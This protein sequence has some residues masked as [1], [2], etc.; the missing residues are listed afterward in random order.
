VVEEQLGVDGLPAEHELPLYD[1]YAPRRS[2]RAAVPTGR[3]ASTTN[4]AAAGGEYGDEDDEQAAGRAAKKQAGRGRGRGAKKQPAGRGKGKAG[5]AGKAAKGGDESD[6]E[7]YDSQASSEGEEE[8]SEDEEDEFGGG[9]GGGGTMVTDGGTETGTEVGLVSAEAM[10]L[11]DYV[12][13]DRVLGMRL[14]GDGTTREYCIKVVDKSFRDLVWR[15]HEWLVA[16]APGKLRGFRCRTAREGLAD[17]GEAEGPEGGV[18]YPTT[19]VVAAEVVPAG[20]FFPVSYLLIDR[21]IAVRSSKPSPGAAA[22]VEY[23]CKWTGLGYSHATWEEAESL[24]SPADRVAVERYHYISKPRGPV[25]R[26][27]WRVPPARQLVQPPVFKPG[28]E[29]RDYQRVSFDWM[30]RNQRA[31][32]NVILGDEMGLGKTAQSVSILEHLRT[33]G[34][35]PGGPFLVVAPL[36][37]LTHWQRE[38]HKWTHMNAV[39]YD[40]SAADKAAC[41]KWDFYTDA[42][43]PSRP[44]ARLRDWPSGTHPFKFDCLLITYDTLR[45]EAPVLGTIMWQAM[46]LDEAHRLKDVNSATSLALRTQYVCGWMLML[47]GTPVQNNLSELFGLLHLLD[48][49]HFP[50]LPDF[51][52]RFCPGGVVEAARMPALAAALKPYLLRRMKEDVE[53]IPE[54]EECVVWVE[55][56]AD[57]RAY[58]KA[59]HESKMHV[60]LAANSRKNMPNSRNLLMELRH[61]CNHPFLLT[62]IQDDFTRRR[63]EAAA[64]AVPPV[65]PPGQVELLVSASGKMVLLAKLLP[66][67]KADGHK[68]LIFSQFKMVLNL[69]QDLCHAMGWPAERLDGDTT[70]AERQAGI[71][72]FNDPDGGGFVYLLSTRAGGMGITLTAADTA[73]IYDSDWNPQQDLQAMARCHRIGQTKSVRVYR[74]VTRGTYEEAILKAA[75]RKFGLDEALLGA[76]GDAD[77]AAGGPDPLADVARIESLLKHGVGAFSE[78]AVAETQRFV[79]EGIEDIL[80]KRVERRQVGS[81]KGNTFST[82]TFVAEEDGAAGGM[83]P[84]DALLGDGAAPSGLGVVGGPTSGAE[85]W[86]SFLP[87]AVARE[88][89]DPHSKR[90]FVLDGPRQRKRVDYSIKALAAAGR[91]DDYDL[92]DESDSDSGG[93]GGAVRTPSWTPTQVSNLET[94]LVSFGFG[95]REA[96]VSLFQRSATVIPK[97]EAEEVA[98]AL[99]E[100]LNIAV[101]HVTGGTSDAVATAKAAAAEE[102]K[103]K[104]AAAAANAEGAGPKPLEDEDV[105]AELHAKLEAVAKPACARKALSS[106]R[107]TLRMQ[108]NGARYALRLAER[109]ALLERVCPDGSTELVEFDVPACG[110]AQPPTPWWGLQEDRDLMRGSL[111]HGFT[112]N[113]PDLW[114]AQHR[115]IRLDPD[116]CFGTIL[117]KLD[118][119]DKARKEAEAAALAQLVG[120][121]AATAGAAAAPQPGSLPTATPAMPPGFD[122]DDGEPAPVAP[123]PKNEP[124]PPPPPPQV[125]EPEAEPEAKAQ[126]HVGE[127]GDAEMPGE[128]GDGG[129]A[130]PRTARGPTVRGP[131]ALGSTRCGSCK[132]CLNPKLKQACFTRRLEEGGMLPSGAGTTTRGPP[133]PGESFWPL[134]AVLKRRL[135]KLLEGLLRPAN[136]EPRPPRKRQRP[137]GAGAAARKPE[138]EGREAEDGDE[139]EEEIEEDEEM[140]EAAQAPPPPAASGK[141]KRSGK[142]TE[143]GPAP[144]PSKGRKRGRSASP[145]AR[146]AGAEPE[147]APKGKQSKAEKAEAS[148]GQAQGMKQGTLPFVIPKKHA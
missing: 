39:V 104:A 63:V 142:D 73:I 70:A 103:E 89:A 34:P 135:H 8:S 29:L 100:M 139:E 5:K 90:K 53:N 2:K 14:A 15:T 31:K 49:E 61:C 24:S 69:L 11:D 48:R 136:T 133:Q 145:D 111:R 66:K 45:K 107:V 58:Y 141:K 138:G 50:S 127:D 44:G 140:G 132:S 101:H 95:S 6:G 83:V 78:A 122:D 85:F 47:T 38:V 123:K 114:K 25:S 91:E 32:R 147:A 65:P 102:E 41:F 126:Q 109:A 76:P 124:Q 35:L 106:R 67:L 20:T 62:G 137:S 98:T 97:E 51:E 57:Q 148:K 60:L 3:K 4:L 64:A 113:S 146:P 99:Q 87:D 74:L 92:G 36:T 120:P 43:K 59:L 16:C 116:L 93:A 82:A 55:M 77:G 68:V 52:E 115:A 33:V 19:D 143:G 80:D 26:N 10:Q 7:E 144:T 128:E 131:L 118:E 18:F 56:T 30:A 117:A 17:E 54:K 134:G 9:G 12:P 125:P 110:R 42:S 88:V 121:E 23:L 46:V 27:Q 130:A 1:Q 79:A 13:V 22:S 96:A 108:R 105:D 81:R 28:C 94:F 40:G 37:T 112:P 129:E 72:R 71:D 21:I 119:Q 86:A 84:E 75:S